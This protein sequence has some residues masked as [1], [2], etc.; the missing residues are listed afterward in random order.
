MKTEK[1]K[2]FTGKGNPFLSVIFK[3]KCYSQECDYYTFGTKPK[4]VIFKFKYYYYYDDEDED[5]DWDE[6]EDEDVRY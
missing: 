2:L 3:F 1:S 4:S 5:V 6:D